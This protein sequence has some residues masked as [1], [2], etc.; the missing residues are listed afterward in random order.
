MMK[1][2][3]IKKHPVGIKQGHIIEVSDFQAKEMIEEGYAIAHG[4]VKQ[5][6]KK[7][8]KKAKK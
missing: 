7:A 1:I 4:G 8:K 6:V 3:F 2:E 5:G